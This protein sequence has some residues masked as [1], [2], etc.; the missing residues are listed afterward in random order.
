MTA[1]DVLII[2]KMSHQPLNFIR[3][4]DEGKWIRLFVLLSGKDFLDEYQKAGVNNQE[5]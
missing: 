3:T 1:F 4:P 2:D 5:R